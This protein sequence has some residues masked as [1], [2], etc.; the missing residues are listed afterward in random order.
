MKTG[1]M[2][3]LVLFCS[4]YGKAEEAVRPNKYYCD[5]GEE[6]QRL[7]VA[8]G[9]FSRVQGASIFDTPIRI[10]D[11]VNPSPMVTFV[12]VSSQAKFTALFPRG[13]VI[14]GMPVRTRAQVS[15]VIHADRIND[16]T[17]RPSNDESCFDGH[18]ESRSWWDFTTIEKTDE[19]VLAAR[20]F[21]AQVRGAS[22][23]EYPVT[24]KRSSLGGCELMVTFK[25]RASLDAFFEVFPKGLQIKRLRVTYRTPKIPPRDE[26][27]F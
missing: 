15:P 12:D 25:D 8:R 11:C 20:A 13:L 17:T 22:R 5:P 14:D 21:F 16:L 6:N 4:H 19:R 23:M 24:L 7:S 3:L 18:Y 2:F 9:F 1:L 10:D 26:F 27:N